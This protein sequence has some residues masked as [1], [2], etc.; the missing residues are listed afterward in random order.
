[1]HHRLKFY[2]ADTYTLERYVHFDHDITDEMSAKFKYLLFNYHTNT[3]QIK[4]SQESRLFN[5]KSISNLDET[6]F[7]FS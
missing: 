6:L 4:I 5:F 2:E 1:M 7:E 3:F